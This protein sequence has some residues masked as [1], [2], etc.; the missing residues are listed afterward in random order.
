MKRLLVFF[1]MIF[2]Q[3]LF[4][5]TQC[6]EKTA[7]PRSIATAAESAQRVLQQLEKNDAPLP[8][9]RVMVPI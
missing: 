7:S 1:A 4:A 9:W 3:T 6:S 5:G 2:S 8:C